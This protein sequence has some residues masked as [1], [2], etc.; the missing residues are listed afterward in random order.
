MAEFIASYRLGA[1][2]APIVRRQRG[3]GPA[4]QVD[5]VLRAEVEAAAVRAVWSHFEKRGYLLRSVEA[6]NTG[7][8]L[9]ATLD[10]RPLL[11][12]VKGRRDATPIVELTPNEFSA[13]NRYHSEYRLCI[14]T[15]AL[16]SATPR[17]HVIRWSDEQGGHV[18]EDGAVAAIQ[19][20]VAARITL[21]Q[22]TSVEE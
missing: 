10:E 7:W 13:L 18:D 4:R 5:P 1:S 9:E 6:D 16:E 14:V 19:E 20:V 21:G 17:V 8:D 11:I 15:N 3:G 12:E 22:R 2:V